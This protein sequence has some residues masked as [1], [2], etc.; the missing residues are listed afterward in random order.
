MAEQNKD[1]SSLH[2]LP[3]KVIYLHSGGTYIVHPAATPFD[4]PRPIIYI[5]S[6]GVVLPLVVDASTILYPH[7]VVLVAEQG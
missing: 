6:N 1:I 2:A 3:Y 7:L 4:A 5:Q